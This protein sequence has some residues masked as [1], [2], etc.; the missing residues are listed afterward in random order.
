MKYIVRIRNGHY[1]YYLRGTT[2]A[3]SKE[4]GFRFDSE[5]EA[6]AALVAAKK[7]TKPAL[8]KIAIIELEDVTPA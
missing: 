8:Y 3:Y 4:R 5:E 1:D 2:W 7:F 6:K